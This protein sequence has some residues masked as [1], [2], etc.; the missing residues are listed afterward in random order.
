MA[1]KVLLLPPLVPLLLPPL[2]VVVVVVAEEAFLLSS[3][4]AFSSLSWASNYKGEWRHQQGEWRQHGM[5]EGGWEE[6][7]EW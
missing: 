2:L 3:A 7:E 1:C 5:R 6:E 4:L